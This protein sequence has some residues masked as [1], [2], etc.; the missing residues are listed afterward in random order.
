MSLTQ[1]LK[2]RGPLRTWFETNCANTQEVA[3][4]ANRAL[5]GGASSLPCPLAPPEGSDVSLVGTAIGYVFNACAAPACLD[6]WPS[7]EGARRLNQ[8]ALKARLPH[9]PS[10]IGER[11]AD[12]LLELARTPALDGDGQRRLCL[13]CLVLARFEQR[14]R[15]G[16]GVTR[17]SIQPLAEYEGGDLAALGAAMASTATVDD[18][19]GLAG[20]AV[21]NGLTFPDATALEF[22]PHFAQ[23]P[24]LGGADADVIADGLLIDFKATSTT[25]VVGYSELWQVVGYALADTNDVHG[26]HSLGIAALRSGRSVTWSVEEL[27][28][29][30][31]A[32]PRRSLEEWRHDFASVVDDM[33]SPAAR[34]SRRVSRNE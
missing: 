26:I 7:R 1:Q 18:L 25:T 27:M 33:P 6:T 21:E 29:T 28:G 16:P 19:V 13:L 22:G 2:Q 30:L 24:A 32:P 4:E 20:A 12:A 17:F 9:V 34:R 8:A 23:T 10:E 31:G 11:T 5:R 15:A 3:T 14:F